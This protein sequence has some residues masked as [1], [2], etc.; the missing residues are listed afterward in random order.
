[1]LQVG[2]G[3]DLLEESLRAEQRGEV[4]MQHLDRHLAVVLQIAS[5]INGCHP[6]R[7]ELMLDRV[8]PGQR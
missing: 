4:G 5:E 3:L 8:A 7:P 2:G 1:M 6:A